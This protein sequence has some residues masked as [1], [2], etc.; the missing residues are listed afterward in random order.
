LFGIIPGTIGA[1]WF[2]L[3]FA[4]LGA[5]IFSLSRLRHEKIPQEAVIGLVYAIAAAVVILV[6]DKAPHGAEHIKELLTGSILWVKWKTIGYAALV[7]AVIGLFHF[8]FR[9]KFLLISNN[10]EKAYQD[11]I[12]VRLWD[13]L[14][15]VSFGLVITHSVGTAG[16]LLVFVFLVVPAITS[17]LMTDVLWK[18]L[19]IGWSLGL[20]VSVLGLYIS[21]I[22]DL[23]SGPTVVAF[24]GLM[25]L[26]VA[27]TLYV[28][29]AEDRWKSL[30][31]IAIGLIG[32]IVI[33]FII[34]VL[35]YAFSNAH[36][37]EHQ[38][39]AMHT[40]RNMTTDNK[41]ND[42]SLKNLSAVHFEAITDQDSLEIYFRASNDPLQKL[43]IAR[44]M[45][46]INQKAGYGFLINLLKHA[47]YIY[48]REEV[49]S[50]IEKISHDRFGYDPEK[51]N[52]ENSSALKKIEKWF[53]DNLR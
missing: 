30:R 27:L 53:Q 23:P 45:T 26:I 11:G 42:Q 6:I 48:F 5:A 10:P 44:R 16:V 47:E 13:F 50:E 9:E 15:Y 2:S 43:D 19:V 12:A 24:Y 34:R 52:A 3:S 28:I 36:E 25:L 51:T 49:I 7:Y 29:R 33:F 22:A 39:S 40:E 14:F 37:H 4:I 8:I 32:T 35:G 38:D 17:I 46:A 21:Y 20:I 1:Y 41:L 31:R 18:Q